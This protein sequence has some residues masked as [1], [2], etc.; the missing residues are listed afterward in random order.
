M[1]FM[2]HVNDQMFD[3]LNHIKFTFW[4]S[5][6]SM[7]RPS[8][9]KCLN[10]KGNSSISAIPLLYFKYLWGQI[11]W[12]WIFWV[13]LQSICMLYQWFKNVIWPYDSFTKAVYRDEDFYLNEDNCPLFLRMLHLLRYSEWSMDFC[14]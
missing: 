3:F 9:S 13:D 11:I 5:L 6:S 10:Y 7:F 2:K 14:S 12:K 8:S 1:F 4:T